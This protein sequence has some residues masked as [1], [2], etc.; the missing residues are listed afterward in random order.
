MIARKCRFA[1]QWRYNGRDCL[2]NHL[3]RRRS[4]KTPKVR[5]TGLSGGIHRWPVNF[6]H[7]GP[8]A[9][10]MFPFE[11][12][13][14]GRRYNHSVRTYNDI[15]ETLSRDKLLFTTIL[16]PQVSSPYIY[17]TLIRSSQYPQTSKSFWSPDDVI[18]NVW[19]N[20]GQSLGTYR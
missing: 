2:L 13:I 4:K 14:M 20:L 8:V 7:K 12:V 6:P 10:Q 19:R 18:Q 9:R 3:F 1:L 17:W 11:D 16:T 5:V 15:R